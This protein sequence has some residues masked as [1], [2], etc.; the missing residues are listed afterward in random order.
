MILSDIRLKPCLLKIVA[1]SIMPR[2]NTRER[3]QRQIATRRLEKIFGSIEN[4]VLAENI[5][6]L[7]GLSDEEIIAL[8][9]EN[10]PD[11]CDIMDH[12]PY[13]MKREVWGTLCE[14]PIPEEVTREVW[15]T[16]YVTL[17]NFLRSFTMTFDQCLVLFPNCTP[18]WFGSWFSEEISCHGGKVW[19][20]QI[21]QEPE[22]ETQEQIQEESEGFQ[23]CDEIEPDEEP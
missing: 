10:I 8:A 11:A 14:N 22:P 9:M 15:G 23:S 16:L 17:V 2:R 21:Q 18:K 3:L 4:V 5:D 13:T 19:L 20:P 7:H 6:I 1:V 12:L